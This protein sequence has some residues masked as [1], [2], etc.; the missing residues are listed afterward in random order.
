MA[1][2][3]PTLS[4]AVPNGWLVKESITLMS[5]DGQA[6]VILSSEPIDPWL[7]SID[8]ALAQG[9]QLAMELPAYREHAFDR[10][11]LFGRYAGFVRELSWTP[12]DG[13]P[14]TQLQFYCAIAGRGYT[15]TAT[16]SSSMFPVHE[17]GLRETLLSAAVDA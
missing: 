6:N 8:Y 5:L 2:Y 11:L 13:V 4:A 15:G 1:W 14:V 9:H 17:P 10:V 3:H 12:H 16:T 7:D